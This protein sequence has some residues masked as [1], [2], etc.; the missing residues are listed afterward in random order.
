[1]HT[2]TVPAA[3]R[4][5]TAGTSSRPTSPAGGRPWAAAMASA[6][7]AGRS[8]GTNTAPSPSARSEA[9]GAVSATA[10]MYSRRSH[11]TRRARHGAPRRAYLLAEADGAGLG[12]AGQLVGVVAAPRRRC[13][14]PSAAWPASSS[15]CSTG[16]AGQRALDA[17]FGAREGR[18][19]GRRGLGDL[20]HVPAVLRV[21]RRRDGVELGSEKAAFSKGLT[22]WPLWMGPRLPPLFLVPVSIEYF[23]ATLT[24][25]AV[26]VVGGQ[27]GLDLEGLGLGLDQDV[28]HGARGR[29]VVGALVGVVVGLHLRLR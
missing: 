18:L 16:S 15:R 26:G 29:L 6:R 28:A 7:S 5:H 3:P 27:Q 8:R 14:R 21:D 1:M 2:V 10:P 24:Q 23:L 11:V 19:L 12:E 20:D 4:S 17:R 25:L 9:A 22:I 13:R